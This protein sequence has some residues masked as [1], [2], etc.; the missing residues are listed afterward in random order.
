MRANLP[1]REP[2]TLARWRAMGLFQRL[3]AAARGRPKFILHD[4]PPYAN[5]NIHIGTA[6]NKILK[7]VVNRSQQMLGRDANYV[8]GWDCHGLPIEWKIEERYRAEGR[9]KDAVP[10][11]EFRREC[12]DF[13]AHWIDVQREEFKRLGVEGD[14]DNPYTTMTPAAE[15]QILREIGKFLTNGGLYKGAK[16]VL[17][18]VV[19]RTA[20]ADA[21]VEYHDHVSTTIWV[22]FPV[23]ASPVPELQGAGVVIWTTTPWTIPGNRAVAYGAAID[24]IALDVR[25][26]REGGRVRPERRFVVAADLRAEFEEA[27]GIVD[28]VPVWS[29]TGA[30]LAGTHCAHPLRG[31]GYDFDVPLLP[32]G[33]VSA[34][35]GTG[36]VHIAPGHG[37]DDWEL[38]RA[39]GIE[40][41]QTVGEDG[42]YFDHV[43]LF[44]GRR[45]LT[46]FGKTGDA[47]DA[48][49]GA[50]AAADALLAQGRLTHSFP[51]SWR[52]KAPLIF[53]NTPQWFISMATND[54][55][56]KA[57]A[58]I[59]ATDFVPPQGRNR[60]YSMIESRPDWCVSRQRAWGVPIAVFV[61]RKT[62]EPLR[63]ARVIERIAAAFESEGADAWFAG[64]PGRFLAPDYDAADYDSVTDIVEVWFESGSTH[65]YV[66]E[67]RAA[68]DLAWPASL[69]L[70]GS[71]QHRGWFHSSLLESCGTRG[72]AP[73]EAVLTHG[74][75]L[76]EQGRKMSKS[77]G[78]VVAPQQ[79]MQQHGADILRLWVVASDYAEDLK[80][81]PEILKH[82]A[83]AYRRLRNTLRYI[84]GALAGFDESERLPAA[85]M[86]ELE[87]WVLHR[88]AELDELVRRTTE[89]YDFHAQFTALYNFCAVD[90]SAFYF[91][92]RKDALYCD[93][94]DS[95]RRRAVRTV[96]DRLFSCLTAWLAPTLCFTAEEAWL[97]RG[98]GPEDSV[99]LRLFPEVPAAWR[100]DALAAR[101][102][103][104]RA[105]RRVVTGALEVARADKRIGSGL[106]AH[107]V[108]HAAAD[109]LA[110][111]DGVDVA[112]IA[113]TS[114]VT[115]VEGPPPAGAF[116]LPE[117]PDVGVRIDLAEGEKC[118]RCWRVL[119]EVGGRPD[120]P[121]LCQR[122]ADA[123]AAQ[124]A[125]ATMTGAGA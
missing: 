122:C 111:L 58:A 11:L 88:L 59:D 8:P 84:L 47:D 94:P 26:V 95:S 30:A 93:R 64:D 99:H 37:A 16:P 63:D 121:D 98:G 123:V 68:T 114:D 78:N 45:V 91:D 18:S 10:I 85:E 97:S 73:Y 53:R 75:V 7:D 110:V 55:R 21:E 106:Q 56:A 70:E 40:V 13:A 65:A 92:V 25:T 72:V 42:A 104:V 87:R 112:E 71:D 29:G 108:L 23:V 9:D 113:I 38:G 44:A 115:L 5:G 1:E 54:L 76:D 52:S 57:L 49:V 89:A 81:G 116:T 19:E 32:G 43:P 3:R 2:Q 90:L 15:A 100:D 48:V 124:G 107:P 20:L 22:R 96:F 51:H 41:P 27:A 33:F 69:Y 17:W 119:P 74:F 118:E 80:I 83:E 102:E 35:D 117:L 67:P 62:G 86:P 12:R 31:Q 36:F 66:L 24:Y 101:W 46:P 60:L 61:D 103:E 77:L 125:A 105:L 120:W 50:L 28:S 109:R 6:L 14:W 39:H 4:G 34:D 79:V 82:H